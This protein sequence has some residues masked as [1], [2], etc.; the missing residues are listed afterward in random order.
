MSALEHQVMIM[1]ARPVT[2]SSSGRSSASASSSKDD[3][4]ASGATLSP[5]RSAAMSQL[6]GTLGKLLARDLLYQAT[7]TTAS[8]MHPPTTAPPLPPHTATLEQAAQHS[9]QC[10][11][12]TTDAAV[13]GTGAETIAP[14]AESH[15]HQRQRPHQPRQPPPRDSVESVLSTG[16]LRNSIVVTPGVATQGPLRGPCLHAHRASK[17]QH[18][19]HTADAAAPSE[20]LPPRV[21]CP[22]P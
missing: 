14:A 19:T 5:E 12:A 15:G 3:E 6:I 10:G 4:M 11:L 13:A 16:K 20:P 9:H 18:T 21:T 8:A 7:T 2:T 17:R 22:P 1:L